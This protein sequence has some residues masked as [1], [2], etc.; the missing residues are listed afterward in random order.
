MRSVTVT[1]TR[2]SA[3]RDAIAALCEHALDPADLLAELETRLRPIVPYDS[4]GWWTIDPE[5]LLPTVLGASEPHSFSGE[6]FSPEDYDAFDGSDR[7]G[8][9]SE[10][11]PRDLRILA[12]SGHATWATAAF[13]R[14]SDLPD[15]TQG[16]AEYLAAVGRYVGAAIREYLA[17]EPWCDGPSKVPGVLVVSADEQVEDATGE[18]VE[19]LSSTTYLQPGELP[20][21]LRGLVRQKRAGRIGGSSPRPSK[22]RI[23]MPEGYWLVARATRFTI[24]ETRSAILL[25]AATRADMRAITMALHSLTEREREISEL[26]VAGVDPRDIGAQLNLSIH[27]VRGYVKTIFGKIG[28]SSRGELTALLGS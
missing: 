14:S 11:E 7:A 19:W 23:R 27:T 26:L 12:R 15:F 16:E 9:D 2:A 22:V 10:L 28:V 17:D 24:D 25:K 13:T 20:A 4:G 3:A 6:L 5:T 18:A 1:G 8:R 21:S